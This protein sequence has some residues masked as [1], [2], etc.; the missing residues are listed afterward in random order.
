MSKAT[1]KKIILSAC[2]FCG[3]EFP[4]LAKHRDEDKAPL[5]YIIDCEGCC[6][7]GPVMG[8]NGDRARAAW[9]HRGGPPENFTLE[10]RGVPEA[11]PDEVTDEKPDGP[12][13]S[14]TEIAEEIEEP[15][16][17]DP[18]PC[19][20]CASTNVFMGHGTA[21]KKKEPFF[22]AFCGNCDGCGPAHD[23][24]EGFAELGWNKRFP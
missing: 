5:V 8:G 1:K 12:V 14:A 22:Y 7:N 15:K 19:P 18:S 17:K 2:P 4:K 16:L 10:A 20:W 3:D 6:A 24:S 13:K 11:I 9:N 21:G 23:T